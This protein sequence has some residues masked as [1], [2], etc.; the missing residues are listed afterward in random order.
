MLMH[1]LMLDIWDIRVNHQR[2]QV[3]YQVLAFPENAEH[4][5]AEIFEA[6]IVQ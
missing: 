5:K 1:V 4:R 2:N 6:C 3:Q